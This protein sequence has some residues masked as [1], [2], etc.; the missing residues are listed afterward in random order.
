MISWC[1]ESYFG[2]VVHLGLSQRPSPQ[3]VTLISFN[4]VMKI[5]QAA[6]RKRKSN[7][8]YGHVYVAYYGW[9]SDQG[10]ILA[11]FSDHFRSTLTKLTIGLHLKSVL[12]TW[13]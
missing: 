9:L 11:H 7:P 5:K 12:L 10:Q 4:Q 2:L 13:L 6:S 1:W 3:T 8:N